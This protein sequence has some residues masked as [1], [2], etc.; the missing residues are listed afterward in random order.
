MMRWLV[1]VMICWVLVATSHA[2]PIPTTYR[3]A[4]H[5]LK[6]S[7][8]NF[9]P[10]SSEMVCASWLNAAP[11]PSGVTVTG[12]EPPGCPQ[13]PPIVVWDEGRKYAIRRIQIYFYGP[14]RYQNAATGVNALVNLLKA[15]YR[16]RLLASGDLS[17]VKAQ[18]EPP[19][20]RVV[21]NPV[22]DSPDWQDWQTENLI[23]LDTPKIRHTT[24]H[25]PNHPICNAYFNHRPCWSARL[26]WAVPVRLVL[27]GDEPPGSYSIVVTLPKESIAPKQGILPLSARGGQLYPVRI[28][29]L[30][31]ELLPEEG[32]DD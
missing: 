24:N 22:P 25:R 1:G 21:K 13:Q 9:M 2:Q 14:G 27:E 12:F 10:T 28:L 18:Y 5:Q 3:Y 31:E 8:L 4:S 17:V 16:L 7:V 6:P 20:R 32:S 26:K 23:E 19:A 15:D 11:N 30:P 29:P